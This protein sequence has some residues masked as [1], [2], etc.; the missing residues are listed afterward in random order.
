MLESQFLQMVVIGTPRSSTKVIQVCLKE[1]QVRFLPDVMSVF[2][3]FL[4]S[5][6]D[7]VAS[8]DSTNIS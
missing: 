1:Y 7:Q 5:P 6:S 2:L 4:E 3:R 8:P